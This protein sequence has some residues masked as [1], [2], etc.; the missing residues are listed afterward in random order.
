MVVTPAG[1]V[2]FRHVIVAAVNQFAACPSSS[3][4]PGAAHA[5]LSSVATM[6]RPREAP[7]H[8]SGVIG[9][10]FRPGGNDAAVRRGTAR[11][12]LMR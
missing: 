10:S 12:T 5:R 3:D 9:A 8:R 4:T 6:A 11:R 2:M 7:R 1:R